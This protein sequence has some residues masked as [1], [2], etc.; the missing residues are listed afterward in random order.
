M[1]SAMARETR[2]GVILGKEQ[3]V[4]SYTALQSLTTG[5]AYQFFEEERKGMLKAGML[6][7]FVILENNPL[8]QS[9][10]KIKDNQIL[11]TIKEGK[12]VYSQ[13]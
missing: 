8:K 4:D 11:S 13:N 6:A 9:L 1:W 2:S 10:D 5:P 7:D 3:R 12:V